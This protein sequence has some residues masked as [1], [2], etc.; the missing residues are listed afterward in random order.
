MGPLSL[1][2][3][4][5]DKVLSLMHWEHL[6]SLLSLRWKASLLLWPFRWFS[7]WVDQGARPPE[8]CVGL[9]CRLGPPPPSQSPA[10][11]LPIAA[12]KLRNPSNS[13]CSLK[14]SF[15]LPL[16]GDIV[17]PSPA[18]SC[19]TMS[20]QRS[21]ATLRS[22]VSMTD[23]HVTV[24]TVR[25]TVRLR[26]VNKRWGPAALCYAAVVSDGLFSRQLYRAAV[27][28]SRAQSPAEWP[29]KKGL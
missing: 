10:P 9:H 23:C 22:A 26:C 6:S 5:I 15:L 28:T 18:D 3:W 27:I 17:R 4:R 24:V 29:K 19:E 21:S 16:S 20:Q 7:W 8:A 2:L 14:H 25:V 11:L 13:S 12:T 1:W